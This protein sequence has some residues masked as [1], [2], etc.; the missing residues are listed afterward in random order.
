MVPD[1]EETNIGVHALL[2]APDGQI[3]LQQRSPDP[4][5]INSG[6]ISLFGGTIRAGEDLIV[7]L[8]REIQEELELDLDESK[9]TLL[10]TYQKTKH[11]DGIDY[12]IHVYLVTNINPKLLVV[13]EGK[14][15]LIET[16]QKLLQHPKLTRIT[17]LALEDY[18]KR[19]LTEV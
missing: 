6:L 4:Q 2:I 17:R 12:R 1:R 14:G 18:I 3:I 5:I 7:G 10:N 15:M 11:L 19:H 16:P 9:I 13:H 8:R